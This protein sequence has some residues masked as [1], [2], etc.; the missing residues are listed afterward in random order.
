M[1]D[2]LLSLLMKA[3]APLARERVRSGQKGLMSVGCIVNTRRAF[4]DNVA[5]P[6]F[7]LQLGSFLISQPIPDRR[8]TMELAKDM[9]TVIT[10]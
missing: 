5:P 1:N 9:G 2:V 8:T 6:A 4:A 10:G 7:G 3:C